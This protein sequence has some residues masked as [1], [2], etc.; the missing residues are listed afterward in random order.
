[1]R[2]KIPKEIFNL[3]DEEIEISETIY[4]GKHIKCLVAPYHSFS[5]LSKVLDNNT[6]TY[7]FP[8]NDQLMTYQKT[9]GFISMVV[10]KHPTNTPIVITTSQSIISD[11]VDGCVRILTEKGDIVPCPTKTFL[12]NLYDIKTHVLENKDLQLSKSEHS[13][14]QSHISGIID[15]INNA[16]NN[17]CSEEYFNKLKD[18]IKDIGEEIIVFQLNNK[19]KEIK[20]IK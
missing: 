10:N 4:D 3:S 19:L 8:E 1:M 11:I 9:I 17:G 13:K 2:L 5:E 7:L 15:N 20:I 16:V 6:D 12:A 14:A 18:S